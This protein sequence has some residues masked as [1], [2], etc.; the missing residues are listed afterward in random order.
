MFNT[1]S[2]LVLASFK[3]QVSQ[4]SNMIYKIFVPCLYIFHRYLVGKYRYS[5]VIATGIGTKITCA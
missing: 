1:V 2:N 3:T 5:Y 4:N